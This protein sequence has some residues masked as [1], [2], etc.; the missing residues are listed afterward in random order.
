MLY[1]VLMMLFFILILF[2]ICRCFLCGC[3]QSFCCPLLVFLLGFY[4]NSSMLGFITIF[5]IFHHEFFATTSKYSEEV[6]V[7]VEVCHSSNELLNF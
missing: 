4:T 6:D 3:P 1:F 5:V 7:R 2:C